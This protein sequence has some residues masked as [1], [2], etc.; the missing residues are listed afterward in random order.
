[1][2][3]NSIEKDINIVEQLY[4]ND[5]II[6]SEYENWKDLDIEH[7]NVLLL[8]AIEKLIKRNEE[9]EEKIEKENGNANR[10]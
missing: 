10:N 1:M 4:D 8:C 6:A 7:K 3:E 2:K 5:F 9:L